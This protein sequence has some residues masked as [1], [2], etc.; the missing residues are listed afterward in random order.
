MQGHIYRG[1]KLVHWSPL[2]GTALV[3]AELEY[4]EGHISRSAYAIFKVVN[5][6]EIAPDFLKG[7]LLSLGLAICSTTPWTIPRNVVVVVNG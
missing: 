7:L 5:I 1:R 4:P 6:A 3:E 2:S